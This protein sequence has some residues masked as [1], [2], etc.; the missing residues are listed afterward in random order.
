[1][2]SDFNFNSTPE[3]EPFQPFEQV[4]PAPASRGAKGFSI[5]ALSLG[6]ASIAGTCCCCCCGLFF[7]PLLCGVLAIVFAI[8]A[9]VRS[10]DKKFSGLAIA[11]LILGIIGVVLSLIFFS[12][13]LVIP[14]M[15]DEE[16]LLEYEAILREELGDEMFEEYFGEIF[17]EELVPLE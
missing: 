9:K 13:L 8:L 2:N 17:S 14:S 4:P 16:F 10:Q 3:Q 6:I 5:A 12:F 1:M 15:I 11:G 7:I